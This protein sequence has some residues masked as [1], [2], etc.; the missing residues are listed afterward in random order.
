MKERPNV[1]GRLP[2]W[3][4]LAIL[5]FFVLAPFY[6]MIITAFKSELQ[7]TSQ[8]GSVFWPQ[9][10]TLGQFQK[11]TSEHPFWTWFRNSAI[12]AI[13]TTIIAVTFAALA[14]Y[15]L[16]RLRFR[17]AQGLTG[18]VLLTYLV[19]GALLFIPLYQILSKL[20]LINTLGSLIATYPT[21]ALPFATWLMMGYF[22]GIPEELENAAMI[23]GAT[24]FQ[25][26]RRITLPLATPALLAVALFTF[27]NS[28]NEFLFAF[29]FI[30][31]QSLQTLPVGL[32]SMIFGDIYPYGQLMAGALLMAV[33]VVIIYS[34]GQKFL[35]E[36]LTAG[37]VKG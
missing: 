2:A 28:F 34:Y 36:G 14:G 20:H 23:D 26:F 25:A 8:Q 4:A 9:P 17:G 15:A 12:V 35:V 19:P 3:V 37:S 18:V 27:T 16:A 32:Q 29:V 22:R 31:K 24:R 10:W 11:L 21:F 1:L 33:P 13:C 30:T 7:V 6:W 5:L